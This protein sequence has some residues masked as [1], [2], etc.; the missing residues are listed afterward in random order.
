[1]PVSRA[2]ARSGSTHEV[3]DRR[4]TARHLHEAAADVRQG[5]RRSSRRVK[6][7]TRMA[8]QTY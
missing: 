3:R 8:E 5:G 2:D 1:M 7:E 4:A 6:P